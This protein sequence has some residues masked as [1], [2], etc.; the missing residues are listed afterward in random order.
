M[1]LST[2]FF[3]LAVVCYAINQLWNHGKL[4]TNSHFWDSVSYLNKYDTKNVALKA[5]LNNWYYKFFKIPYKE[6]F[7]G[8]ATIFVF[9]TDGMHLTQFLF[10]LFIPLAMSSGHLQVYWNVFLIYWTVWHITFTLA[11][12]LLSK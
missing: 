10:N 11:Y 6:R 7:P 2:I 1:I 12:K 3:A 9:L 8:S 5:P 4:K